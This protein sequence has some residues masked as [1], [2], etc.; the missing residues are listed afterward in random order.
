MFRR[1]SPNLS[2]RPDTTVFEAPQ[3]LADDSGLTRMILSRLR[4]SHAVIVVYGAESMRGEWLSRL[5]DFALQE[6]VAL[7]PVVALG[8]SRG[9]I[10][11]P[12]LAKAHLKHL[13]WNDSD[14][15]SSLRSLRSALDNLRQ[16]AAQRP[17]LPWIYISCA[18]EDRHLATA[19]REHLE[20]RGSR[21][22]LEDR[23]RSAA[24]ARGTE[25][26]VLTE[27]RESHDRDRLGTGAQE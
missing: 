12:L 7:L 18:P 23:N 9:E 24:P 6:N 19:I 2:V 8:M 10:P 25:P 26:R 17:E 27:T 11:P 13:I 5:V 14:P 15:E 16:P 21:V 22:W 20:N 1:G 4:E 3:N